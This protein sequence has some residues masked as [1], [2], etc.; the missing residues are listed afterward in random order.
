MKEKAVESLEELKTT[1]KRWQ[2]IEVAA[3][4]NTTAVIERTRNPLIKLVMEIIRAYEE[5][6][7][8]RPRNNKPEKKGS[9]ENGQNS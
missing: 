4:E 6:E 8:Q 3:V 7:G 2:E 9:S 5:Y 1:L